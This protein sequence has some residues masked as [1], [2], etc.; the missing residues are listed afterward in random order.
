MNKI[1]CIEE[2]GLI[3]RR[4]REEN[5]ITQEELSFRSGI[6]RN[7]IGLIERGKCDPKA[8]TLLILCNVL[9]IELTSLNHIKD[10][11]TIDNKLS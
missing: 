2:I 9:N 10:T 8:T 5:F 6:H 4:Y 3:I 11:I 7:Q 1:K